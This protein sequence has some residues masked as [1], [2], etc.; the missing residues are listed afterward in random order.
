M[1][2]ENPVIKI[3]DIPEHEMRSLATET[4][5]AVEKFFQ[6]PRQMERYEKW[7]EKYKKERKD[8]G[9]NLI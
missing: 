7:L 4:L 8:K 5:R 3:E 2:E 1:K 6:Q 9:E